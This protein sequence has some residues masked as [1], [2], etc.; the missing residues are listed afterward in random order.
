VLNPDVHVRDTWFATAGFHAFAFACIAI[1]VTALLAA[2][3]RLHLRPSARLARAS[4]WLA[5]PGAIA[6]IA[7]LAHAGARGRAMRYGEYFPEIELSHRIAAA[8]TIALALAGLL[9]A[10]AFLARSR[11]A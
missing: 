8:A 9:L 2:A 5:G 1:V 11:A 3:E 4:A 10:A 6:F 7:A